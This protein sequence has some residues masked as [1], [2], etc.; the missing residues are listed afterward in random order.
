MSTPFSLG[1]VTLTTMLS[2]SLSFIIS[3]VEAVFILPQ[4]GGQQLTLCNIVP[5]FH[6]Y[7]NEFG[8]LSLTICIAVA[9]FLNNTYECGC[10]TV[11]KRNYMDVT[12]SS[13]LSLQGGCGAS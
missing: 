7:M 8:S 6:N 10:G 13:V 5:L 9:V 4:V 3:I 12:V 1:V 11:R 2:G